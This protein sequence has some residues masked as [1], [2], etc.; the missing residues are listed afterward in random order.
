MLHKTR[1]AVAGLTLVLA[2]AGCSGGSGGEGGGGKDGGGG[3]ADAPFNPSQVA[4]AIPSKLAAPKGWLAQEPRVLDG[5]TAREQCETQGQWSCAGLTAQATTRHSDENTNGD[6]E[7]NVQFT[8]LAY[9]SV[10]NAKA[11]MKAAVAENHKDEKT[12]PKRL[13]IDTAADETDAFA[14]EDQG[15][16]Y[17]TAEL[18]VGSVVAVMFG[19]NLPKDHELPS[20][21]KMQVDR[22]TTSA[23]G[24]NP[25]A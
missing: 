20:F 13:T 16:T 10:D 24:K 5:S 8:L 22:I 23:T 25:D 6:K 7:V 12:K 14:E 4:Q 18:R 11:A 21:V 19:R 15:E 2:L 9:D 17:Q 3:L 1:G